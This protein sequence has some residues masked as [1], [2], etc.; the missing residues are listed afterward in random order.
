MNETYYDRTGRTDAIAGGVKVI[1]VTTPLGTF[2][3]W[4]KRVPESVRTRQFRRR[5]W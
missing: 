1:P 4:T 3:V 5:A 2:K